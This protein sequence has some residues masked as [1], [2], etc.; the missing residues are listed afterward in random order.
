MLTPQEVLFLCSFGVLGIH[1]A[2]ILVTCI[3]HLE[4]KKVEAQIELL[5]EQMREAGLLNE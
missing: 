2:L 1:A 4:V 3:V 5:H